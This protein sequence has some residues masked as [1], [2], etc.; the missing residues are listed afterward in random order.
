MRRRG[1][2][3]RPCSGRFVTSLLAAMPAGD[4]RPSGR[5]LRCRACGRVLG[6]VR[7]ARLVMRHRER[8]WVVEPA[9]AC[10]ELRCEACGYRRRFVEADW[11]PTD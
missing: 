11:A 9:T 1:E 3:S 4:T 10:R 5:Q 7:G 2:A 6:V 8:E